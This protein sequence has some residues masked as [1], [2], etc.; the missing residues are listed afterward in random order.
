MGTTQKRATVKKKAG[1]KGKTVAAK[2]RQTPLNKKMGKATNRKTYEDA[3]A[4]IAQFL[5]MGHGTVREQDL[6]QYARLAGI[7]QAY[8]QSV[9]TVPAPKTFEGL[10]EWKMFE[11]KMKQ[12][13][14]ARALNVSDAKLSLVMSGKQKP[15]VLLLKSMHERLG[16]DGN[17]LLSLVG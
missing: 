11:L 10:L 4:K 16:I 9:Y 3:M 15:D 1:V 8:E 6:A 5:E 17:V 12:R 7:A 14:L 2:S 13:E